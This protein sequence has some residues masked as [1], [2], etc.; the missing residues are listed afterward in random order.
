MSFINW[1]DTE[2]MVGLLTEYVADERREALSDRSRHAFLSQLFRELTQLN[3]Q[4]ATL[5]TDVTIEKLRG[6]QDSLDEEFLQDPVV[7]HL[8]ACIEELERISEQSA[9]K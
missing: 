4:F 1:S 7:V 6:I 8:V 5:S 2:E 3:E 9:E